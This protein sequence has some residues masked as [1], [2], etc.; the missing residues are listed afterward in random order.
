MF[1]GLNGVVV[2]SHGGTDAVGFAA[3]IAVAADLVRKG[4]QPKDHRRD[5]CKRRGRGPRAICRGVVTMTLRSV[6]RGIGAYLPAR[7]MHNAELAGLV[8]TSDKWVRE[9]T[10]IGQ[11]HLAADGEL[12]SDLAIERRRAGPEA[13]RHRA[14]RPRSDPGRDLDARTTPSRPRQPRSSASSK[15]AAASPSTCRPCAPVRLRARHRR[16][17][18]PRRARRRPRW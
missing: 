8:D 13:G 2:K 1:L 3:A 18:H 9:R 6:I 17:F 7:V 10:G 4:Y 5:G 14:S 15:P 16:Q 12:T 11:R